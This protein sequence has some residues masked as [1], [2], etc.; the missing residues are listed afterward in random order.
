MK[1]VDAQGRL[2]KEVVR[3][4]EAEIII[5]QHRHWAL[6]IEARRTLGEGNLL[7]TNRRLLFLHK[8]KASPQVDATMKKLVGSPMETVLDHALTLHKDSFEIPLPSIMRA[9]IG[10]F[11]GFPFPSFHLSVS[12]LKG[13]KQ[14]PYTVAFQFKSVK[15]RIFLTPQI[16][17]DWGWVRV[18][19]RAAQKTDLPETIK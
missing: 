5:R 8:I 1:P 3:D 15:S 16:F 9:G 14:T 19:R 18:I 11:R 12:Y 13:K 7:L 17:K 10:A 2:E 4:S 6:W